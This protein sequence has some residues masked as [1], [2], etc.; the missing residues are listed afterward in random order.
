MSTKLEHK[1]EIRV[2]TNF[3]GS[4]NNPQALKRYFFTYT[5]EITNR[6]EETIQLVSRSW[7]VFEGDGDFTMVQGEGVIGVQPKIAPNAT[8]SYTS[9]CHLFAPIGKMEGYYTFKTTETNIYFDCLIPPFTLETDFL[10][11]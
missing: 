5:I 8:F 11:N 1:I 10:K 3:K 4:L 9:G 7:D 6:S 2:K